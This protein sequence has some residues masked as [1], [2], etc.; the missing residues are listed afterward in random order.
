MSTPGTPGTRGTVLDADIEIVDA[1][2]RIGRLLGLLPDGRPYCGTWL[3][4][5]VTARQTVDAAGRV[6]PLATPTV[7]YRTELAV[8]TC[9][10][11]GTV[12]TWGPLGA[13]IPPEWDVRLRYQPPAEALLS[14]AGFRRA[15][16]GACPHIPTLYAQLVDVFDR[17]LDLS[18]GIAGQRELAELLAVFVLATWLADAFATFPYLWPNGDKGSGKTKLLTLVAR[19]SYLGQVILAGGTYAAL[20]DL[21]EYGATLCF[22][23][24]ENLADP[25]TSDPDKRALLLAGNR[26]GVT[27][28]VKEPEGKHGWRIRNV[29]AYTPKVFS[30][31]RLP[32]PVLSRRTL[33]VPLVRS[34]DADRANHDA[35]EDGAWPHP[36]RR[37]V[38]DLWAFGLHHLPAARA[39]YAATTGATGA[40]GGTRSTPSTRSMRSTLTGPGF[41]PWRPLLATAR[42][43]EDAGVAGLVESVRALAHA[44]QAER[45]DL[46]YPDVTRLAV[47]AVAEIAGVGDVGTLRDTRDTN[48]ESP[49]GAGWW[50]T[51]V[52]FTAQDV[53][54]RVNA[55]ARTV[56]LTDPDAD[57][58]NP[59][60][61]GR[62]L[63]RLRIKAVRVAGGKRTREREITR[64]DA[65]KL[66]SA[67][68]PAAL[69]AARTGDAPP[70]ARSPVVSQTSQSVPT[71][72]PPDPWDDPPPAALTPV[73]SPKLDSV[74]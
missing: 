45:A 35:D 56:G 60:K 47:L 33:V 2:F 71:S 74:G 6:V 57:F 3:T 59:T 15:A 63:N 29:S 43:V 58:T 68:A 16:S 50:E 22:D 4:L 49:D 20:R 9:E 5:R 67:Y 39:A 32:D 46:E 14:S 8:L 64:R 17:F 31:I 1:P 26:K 51:P 28:P 41:E 53:V 18:F 25:R 65:Y 61:I 13:S 24:A 70:E 40:E 19:L 30:A 73:P 38:D 36:R 48:A 12:R 72:H 44:Y 54:T 34:A 10:P 7:E 62:T 21:A 66:L 27:V 52:R 23:D 55:E 11:D 42:V 69:A 37:L